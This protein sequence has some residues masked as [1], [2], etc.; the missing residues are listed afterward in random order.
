MDR[1]NLADLT[2]ATRGVGKDGKVVV[3]SR[4]P[5]STMQHFGRLKQAVKEFDNAWHDA[6]HNVL[7]SFSRHLNLH[8]E[9]FFNFKVY[10]CILIV[11][12]FRVKYAVLGAKLARKTGIASPRVSG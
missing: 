12:E 7:V 1:W 4:G 3:D 10:R 6:N 11:P 9:L 2:E 5:R 8:T